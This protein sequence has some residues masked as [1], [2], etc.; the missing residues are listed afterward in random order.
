MT[1]IALA[2]IPLYQQINIGLIVLS[3][4]SLIIACAWGARTPKAL[5]PVVIEGADVKPCFP[6]P[7]DYLWTV[8][9]IGLITLLNVAASIAPEQVVAEE[10]EVAFSWLDPAIFFAIHIPIIIRLI[11]TAPSK[12]KTIF[13]PLQWLGYILTAFVLTYSCNYLMQLG[14]VL[15]WFTETCGSPEIQEALSI[16]Q[17]Y[18]WV[19]LMPHIV[20][21][22]IV[23]PLVEECLFRGMLYPCIKKFLKPTYA[24]IFTGF[25]FGAIHMALPQMLA[26][27]FLGAFLCFVYERVKTLWLPIIIHA[28]FNGFNVLVSIYY[29]DLQALSESLEQAAL[30]S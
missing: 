12:E 2:A 25:I 7:I 28:S 13:D 16:F 6:L 26:L 30:N 18:S 5:A 23:A 3:I 1:P 11:Q 20:S 29:E 4:L 22:C 21:A 24:A 10:S 14:P 8:V 17:E 19:E 9:L 27:S 15:N